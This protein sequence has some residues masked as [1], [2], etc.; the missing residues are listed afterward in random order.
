MCSFFS[1][2]QRAFVKSVAEN[3]SEELGS[4]LLGE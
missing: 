3:V 4:R 1:E 2:K